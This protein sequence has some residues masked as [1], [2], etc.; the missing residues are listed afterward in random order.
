M[1]RNEGRR[2]QKPMVE[3]FKKLEVVVMRHTFT[4]YDTRRVKTRARMGTW[5]DRLHGKIRK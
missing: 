3:E 5:K 4:L 2:F 1:N